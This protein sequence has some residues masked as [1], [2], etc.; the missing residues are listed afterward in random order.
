MVQNKE[1]DNCYNKVQKSLIKIIIK[2]IVINIIHGQTVWF[3]GANITTIKNIKN[4]SINPSV[5]ESFVLFDI[6]SISLESNQSKIGFFKSIKILVIMCPSE[7]MATASVVKILYKIGISVKI[8]VI[9]VVKTN[10]EYVNIKLKA[11]LAHI[12]FLGD[13]GVNFA[14]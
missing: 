14:I 12:C 3:V 11:I 6:F 5:I 8:A 2:T 13:V 7:I 10:D 4:A 1:F 9:T